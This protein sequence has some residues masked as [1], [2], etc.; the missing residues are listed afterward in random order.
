MRVGLGDLFAQAHPD[1]ASKSTAWMG[2]KIA[3]GALRSRSR[4]RCAKQPKVLFVKI[5]TIVDI[6]FESV[7]S[8]PSVTALPQDMEKGSTEATG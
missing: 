3:L 1:F 2:R 7:Y 5:D 8:P 6:A 4:R